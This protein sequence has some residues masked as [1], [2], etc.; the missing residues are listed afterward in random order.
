[1]GCCCTKQAPELSDAVTAESRGAAP[2]QPPRPRP[3]KV[4]ANAA[5]SALTASD[6]T[7]SNQPKSLTEWSTEEVGEWLDGPSVNLGKYRQQL[8][9]MGVDGF[10][11]S[12]MKPED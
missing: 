8:A 12:R 11:V 6:N 3:P 1:M 10:M 7:L 9:A 2:S 4:V 5:A